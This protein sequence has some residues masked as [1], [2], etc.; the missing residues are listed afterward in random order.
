MREFSERLVRWQ[1][2]HGR[3]DLP[4]QRTRDPYRIWVS[5]IMLQQTQ[6]ATVIP[7]YERF[8]A[9]F[10]AV[11]CLAEAELDDV[12]KLWSG[13]GY[14][15]RARNLHRAARILVSRATGRRVFPRDIESLQALPGIG[16]STAAAIA[17][18]AYAARVA[19][20]DGNVKR[21]LSRHFLVPGF[22]GGRQAE[23]RLWAL[24]ES[25][26]PAQDI[27]GYTQALMDL[28]AT[29]CT[30][31]RPLC[32]QCPVNT[33]CLAFK[34]NCVAEYPERRPHKPLPQRATRM[35][36]LL[37]RAEILLVKRP[38]PGIWGGLWCF[39]ELPEG[40]NPDTWSRERYGCDIGFPEVLP[41]LAHGFTHFR[42]NITP[43]VCRVARARPLIAEPGRAWFS[44]Q[45]AGRQ[46]I[47]APVRRILE[48]IAGRYGA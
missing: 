22:P 45:Q 26:L 28:G 47:P 12:L 10:P 18:F 35:L 31:A 38:A 46:A 15:S 32:D 19:I 3:H 37:R 27:E 42:L 17:A 41:V 11:G 21:V 20:L 48:Q 39:P 25:L 33:T 5:E 29:R 1:K 8:L 24:A 16:R 40:A 2:A 4:W 14:Y 6:V 13:L 43:L 23:T 34:L 36:L 7:Y 9:R 30:R 44:R